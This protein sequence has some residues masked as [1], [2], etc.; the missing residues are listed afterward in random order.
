MR[1]LRPVAAAILA[2]FVASCATVRETPGDPS[3]APSPTETLTIL[4]DLP[5]YE[6]VE[7][8]ASAA[9]A[10]VKARVI[11][12]RSDLDLPDYTSDDPRVNPY[13]G[14]SE[15]PSP[16]EIKAMGIPITVYTVEI[17]ES[18]AGKLSERSTIEVVEMGGL[19]DGIDHRVANLQ[20]LATSKT[21]LLFL[22]EVRDGRYA[23]VGMAQG[24]FTALS[25]GS[26]A[27]LSDTPLKIGTS[28][29]LQRLEQVVDG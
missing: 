2:L 6:S 14:A 17:T 8:L 15:A 22:E 25:D 16:E 4:V 27:S 26:Y 3:V 5:H 29:D 23:T 28:A 1:Y 13:I 11:S 18:L 9:D 19:V 24:R 7:D 20:P 21:D 12:S 10:I